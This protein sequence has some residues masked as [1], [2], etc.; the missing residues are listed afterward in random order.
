[1]ENFWKL[2]GSYVKAFLAIVIAFIISKGSIYNLDWM[3]LLS[4]SIMSFLP[5]IVKAISGTKTGFFNTVV[6][7]YVKTFVTV[8]LAYI[9]AAGSIYNLNWTELVNTAIMAL[10]PVFLNIVNPV[11]TRYGLN[12]D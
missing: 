12:K 6:G 5:V 8:G 4:S 9:I 7:G 2:A 11:D 10:L 1:M 3:D